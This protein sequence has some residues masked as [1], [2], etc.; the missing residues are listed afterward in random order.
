MQIPVA[1]SQT[2]PSEQVPQ[3]A[4]VRARLHPAKATTKELKRRSVRLGCDTSWP[5]RLRPTLHQKVYRARPASATL[6]RL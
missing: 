4:W 2:S 6:K 5:R 3:R 1:V